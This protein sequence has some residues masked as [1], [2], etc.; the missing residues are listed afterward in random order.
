MRDEEEVMREDKCGVRE[1]G[2][3]LK[4]ITTLD[5]S[6]FLEP[7]LLLLDYSFTCTYVLRV[8]PHVTQ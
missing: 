5:R 8:R 4:N 3:I 7:A 1:V 2:D 6:S